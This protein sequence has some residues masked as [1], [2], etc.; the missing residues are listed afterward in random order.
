MKYFLYARKSEEDKYKQV[1]SIPDQLKCLTGIKE[2]L[3]LEIQDVISESQSAKVPGRPKFN[4]MIHR[5]EIGEADGI[6]VWHPNRLS[7]NTEDL[8]QIISLID[9]GKLSE[10]IT[11]SQTFKNNPM[12]KFMLGF[13]ML[14]SK[15][16]NDNKSVDVKR[17]LTT[18]A[19]KGWLPG[20]AKPGY[21]NSKLEKK[22]EEYQTKD[23]IRFPL[24]KSCWE[25][26][27]TG[28]YSPPQILRLLNNEWGYRTVERRSIGGKPMARSQIY[29]IFTDSFYYGEYE[30]P[31]G[32]GRW[33][34]GKHDFMITKDDFD[35]VQI[36]LGRKGVRRPK[37][38][39]FYGTGLMK[40][41]ECEGAITCE[42]KWQVICSG[43][44]NKFSSVSAQ[45][46]PQCKT[47]ISQ[48]V[49]PKILHYIYYHCA[50]SRNP[51]CTQKSILVEDLDRQIDEILS[52]IGIN[53]EF[54]KWAIKYLNK[55]NESEVTDRNSQLLSLQKAEASCITKLDNLI[56][57]YISP[58]N[59]DR[60]LLS[61]EELLKEKKTLLE[62]K[63]NIK[64]K[65]A[66]MDS[67]INKW[68][69]N[70]EKDFNYITRI[71]YRFQNSDPISKR[72]ILVT[73]CSNLILKDK[74]LYYDVQ[75]PY[76]TI[77]KMVKQERTISELFEPKKG[78]ITTTQLET[79]WSQNPTLYPVPDSNWRF[80][81]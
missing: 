59:T 44:K 26:M 76:F 29:E 58:Q 40:C 28:L 70:A 30:Y 22:G 1:Q 14:Q 47:D 13:L 69:D 74:T 68:L 72:Q 6:L 9:R 46:C 64:E 35:K 60:S 75:E 65:L 20:I 51:K 67:R 53:D 54:N 63:T 23:P 5:L 56:K 36:L 78:S 21:L 50:K 45:I 55:L 19:E 38:K 80:S 15:L 18:K 27:L 12:D 52:E 8:A 33:Y 57:L 4:S 73:V 61:D 34:S 77:K 16:E 24:I 17:G 66:K 37:K 48:M 41:G 43:C 71:K 49:N 42:E 39:D 25:Y 31:K 11:P 79:S 32:S 3:S 7:R 10:V 81:G 2:R 62:E